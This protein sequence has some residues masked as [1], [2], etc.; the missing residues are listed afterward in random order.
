MEIDFTITGSLP[1]PP[2]EW[3]CPVD[4]ATDASLSIRAVKAQTG[5]EIVFERTVAA[6]TALD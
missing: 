2:P 4:L 5:L 3:D 1:T 6:L